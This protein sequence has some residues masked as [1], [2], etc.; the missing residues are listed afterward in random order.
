MRTHSEFVPI[1]KI[2]IPFVHDGPG[3]IRLKSRVFSMQ[4]S[5]LSVW[6]SFLRINP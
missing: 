3:F 4:R 1:H 5:F 6:W 2:L